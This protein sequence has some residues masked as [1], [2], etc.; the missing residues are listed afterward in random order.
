MTAKIKL[1]AASG[2]GSFSLQA[3]SSSSNNRVFTL[4]DIADATMA[5]VNGITMLDQYYLNTQ[6]SGTAG[7]EIFMNTNFDRVTGNITGAAVIGTGM[8]KS[9]EVFSFPSTG[10]YHLR[11]RSNVMLDSGT[12][13]NRYAENK[14][15]VTTNN[16]GSYSLVSMGLD[17]IVSGSGERFGNPIA[18]FYF[19]VTDT[20]T[21]KCKFSV[22]SGND[23]YKLI[24]SGG[25][26][27]T[28]VNFMKIGDT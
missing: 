18:E 2:G 28:V 27:D 7:E 26:L 1:N 19:D 13:A 12:S 6:K 22:Q 24:V 23:A 5:T 11:F 4:P 25:R 17:G 20:S 10:I 14:I 16:G 9:S 3:P 8:T 21:H 15:Y